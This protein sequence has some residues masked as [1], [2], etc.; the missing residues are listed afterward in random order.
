MDPIEE[1]AASETVAAPTAVSAPAGK[2]TVVL[3]AA[4]AWVG[5][6]LAGPPGIAV[7]AGVGWALDKIRRRLIAR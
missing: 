2:T 4:G 1:L 5:G 3:A 7:G 6:V